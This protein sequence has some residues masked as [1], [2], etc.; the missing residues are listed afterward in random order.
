MKIK[1]QHVVSGLRDEARPF[2]RH[3]TRGQSRM[4]VISV[5]SPVFPV[6]FLGL[7]FHF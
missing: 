5:T 7:P 6:L 4:I 1:K 3:K 2:P